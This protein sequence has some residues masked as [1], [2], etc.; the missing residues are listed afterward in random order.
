M[1]IEIHVCHINLSARG[2]RRLG[3]PMAFGL[4]WEFPKISG[5]LLLGSLL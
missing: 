4:L 2:G 5:Y 3:V 1:Q